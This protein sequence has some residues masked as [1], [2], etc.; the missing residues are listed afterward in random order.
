MP[1][2]TRHIGLSRGAD[3]CWPLAFGHGLVWAADDGVHGF[4]PWSWPVSGVRTLL[5]QYGRRAF[6][7]SDPVLGGSID[8]TASRLASTDLGVVGLGL[9][10]P[11]P[12]PFGPGQFLHLDPVS[13][14]GGAIVLPDASG[15]WNASLP[16]A[17]A[18]A[19]IGLDLVAQP[20]F[21]APTPIG[22]E[23]GHAYWL[24]LGP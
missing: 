17:A 22:L 20:L 23:V 24:T 3:I 15:R 4:E 5:R 10:V 14:L 12:L 18:P 19:L 11:M 13:A 16:L 21:L 2:V 1:A 8:F 6:E 7:V 9:P